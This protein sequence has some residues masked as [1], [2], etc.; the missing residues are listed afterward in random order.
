[1][2]KHARLTVMVLGLLFAAGRADATT[3]TFDFTGTV[4]SND[5]NPFGITDLSGT[6]VTGNF[7]YDTGTADSDADPTRGTY[8]QQN[9][10]FTFTFA[11]GA[12][13]TNDGEFIVVAFNDVQGVGDAFQVGREQPALVNGVQEA[14]AS[15]ALLL[16]DLTETVFSSD[17]LP[18]TLNLADFAFRR[19]SLVDVDREG[20]SI[21]FGI[22]TLTAAAVP[23]PEPGTIA[24][25]AG[26]LLPLIRRFARSRARKEAARADPRVA[27]WSSEVR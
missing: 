3:L 16:A 26:G 20:V 15:A 4:L 7:S 6:P 21:A 13:V 27:R 5:F 11:S 9:V 18:A 19:G 17:A 24:L 8:L 1:M 22:D 10:M 23:V 12:T 2:I 25:L 14:S